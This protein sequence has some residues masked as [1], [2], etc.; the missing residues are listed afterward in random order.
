MNSYDQRKPLREL[1]LNSGSAPAG[2]RRE[3]L[4]RAQFV[5]RY[6]NRRPDSGEPDFD[7]VLRFHLGLDPPDPPKK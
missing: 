7:P 6:L 3:L 5:K 2:P 1:P 4:A